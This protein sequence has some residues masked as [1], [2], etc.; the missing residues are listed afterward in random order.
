[1][2]RS[3]A[4]SISFFLIIASLFFP[5]VANAGQRDLA[6]EGN[7]YLGDGQSWGADITTGSGSIGFALDFG[8]GPVTNRTF[9]IDPHG[10]VVF[11]S[12]TTPTGDFI[13]PL[14]APTPFAP[15]SQI[16]YAAGLLDPS[17]I[18]NTTPTTYNPANGLQAI[19]FYFNGVCPTGQS[20]CGGD[21]FQAVLIGLDTEHFVL[22]LNY[23]AFAPTITGGSA[24]FKLGANTASFAGPYSDVGP[25]YCFSNG[26][27]RAF[28]TVAACTAAVVTNP[29]V[30]EPGEDLLLLVG[31]LALVGNLVIR[32]RAAKR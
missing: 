3:P 7:N 13:A 6:D 11:T 9:T 24:S 28:T 21:Q 4:P 23:G 19:R 14:L 30:P 26:V 15:A 1:M 2:S 17:V 10:Q 32:R 29:T 18:D 22:E 12:G 5:L 25:D 27:A 31:G 20:T 16:S 8:L